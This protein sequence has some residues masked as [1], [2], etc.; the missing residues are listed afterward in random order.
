VSCQ[1]DGVSSVASIL[2]VHAASSVEMSRIGGRC[3][4]P[5]GGGRV[6]TGAWSGPGRTLNKDVLSK[7]SFTVGGL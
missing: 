6:R 1:C 5:M 4:I 2:E 3:N 7:R